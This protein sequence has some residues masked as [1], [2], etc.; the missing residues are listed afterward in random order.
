[1]TCSQARRSFSLLDSLR[2]SRRFLGFYSG[3]NFNNKTMMA[4]GHLGFIVKISD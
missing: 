1:M 2:S 4:E 3:A